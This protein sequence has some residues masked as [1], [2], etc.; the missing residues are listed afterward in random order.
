M[1]AAEEK[2]HPAASDG[3]HVGHAHNRALEIASVALSM[4]ATMFLALFP[5]NT[6]AWMWLMW[7][8]GALFMLIWAARVR[9]WGVGSLNAVYLVLDLMGLFRLL[10]AG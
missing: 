10:Q 4:P 2:N 1:I 7:A 9:A 8:A 3:R 6:Q 5:T